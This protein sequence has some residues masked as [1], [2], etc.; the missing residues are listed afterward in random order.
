MFQSEYRTRLLSETEE[1]E[2][3]EVGTVHEGVI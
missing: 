3:G 2:T 1:V